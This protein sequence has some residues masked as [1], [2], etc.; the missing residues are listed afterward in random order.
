MKDKTQILREYVRRVLQESAPSDVSSLAALVR[1]EGESQVILFRY[2]KIYSSLSRR[3]DEDDV[4]N[5]LL[6]NIKNSIVGYGVFGPPDKGEAY[7]AWEVT[8][9]AAPGF[10]KI[11]YGIGYALSPSGLL[12][13]DRHQVSPE[14]EQAWKKASR[15]RE[16]EKLDDLPPN[17]KTE[18]D[19]DD[20]ELHSKKGKDFLDMAYKSQGWEKG[21]AA[22]LIA[23]GKTALKELSEDVNRDESAIRNAF[24]AMGTQFFRDQYSAML[25]RKDII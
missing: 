22:R 2:D 1:E 11:L 10:G 25:K 19:F 20:A 13:P 16:K 18:D 15:D 14:A 24:F 4:F 12:M 8:H 7:G 21:V 17:N 3:K 23:Q 6:E 5:F 9:A